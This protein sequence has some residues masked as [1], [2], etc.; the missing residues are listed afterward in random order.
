MSAG[1]P[2][3]APSAQQR[4]DSNPPV[5]EDAE[6]TQHSSMNHP[7]PD[8]ESHP[9]LRHPGLND[10]ENVRVDHVGEEREDQVHRTAGSRVH[11]GQGYREQSE[12][13]SGNR[14]ADAPEQLRQMGIARRLN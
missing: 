7:P 13:E 3:S 5:E 8:V 9:A 11:E 6:N 10:A 1:C 12:H 4:T 14:Q 2:T